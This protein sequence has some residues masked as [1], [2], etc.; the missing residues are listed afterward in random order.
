MRKSMLTLW[1]G[2]P[3]ACKMLNK[4]PLNMGK[5]ECVQCYLS[6]HRVLVCYA[7]RKRTFISHNVCIY[8]LPQCVISGMNRVWQCNANIISLLR[9]CPYSPQLNSQT[10]TRRT[11]QNT[12][13]WSHRLVLYI[14]N[15]QGLGEDKTTFI[16]PSRSKQAFKMLSQNICT[17]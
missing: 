14:D 12:L 3:L 7:K 4:E 1:P 9:V 6:P 8:S 11:W 17:A 15:G 5:Q 16:H 10:L 2:L 13:M